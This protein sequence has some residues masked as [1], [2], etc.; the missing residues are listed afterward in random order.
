MEIVL[1]KEK[2]F[3]IELKSINLFKDIIFIQINDKNRLAS[4]N[5]R[6]IQKQ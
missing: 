3:Y 6:Q 4:I 1:S 5:T 2:K